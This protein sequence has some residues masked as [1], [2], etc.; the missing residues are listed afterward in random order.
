MYIGD[1]YYLEIRIFFAERDANLCRFFKKALL[2]I[3]FMY[4]CAYHSSNIQQLQQRLVKNIS[5]FREYRFG[6]AKGKG[7]M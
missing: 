6:L 1:H 7:L 2:R 3:L 5:N 4:L